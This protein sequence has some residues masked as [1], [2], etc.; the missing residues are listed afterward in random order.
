MEERWEFCDLCSRWYYLDRLS[1][2]E[3]RCPVCGSTPAAT[4][5]RDAEPTGVVR[6]RQ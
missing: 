5:V 4:E 1:E 2:R 3:A 6:V